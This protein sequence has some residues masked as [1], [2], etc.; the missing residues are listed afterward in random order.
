VDIFMT[1]LPGM[2]PTM[3]ASAKLLAQPEVP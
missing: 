1:G 2:N 3:M